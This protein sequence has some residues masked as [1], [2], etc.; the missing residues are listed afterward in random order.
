MII[1]DTSVKGWLDNYGRIHTFRKSKNHKRKSASAFDGRSKPSEEGTG[2]K[3]EYD[4]NIM[5]ITVVRH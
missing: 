2:S 1:L 4:K 3:E 5:P